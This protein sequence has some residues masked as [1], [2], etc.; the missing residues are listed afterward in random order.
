MSNINNHGVNM[1][2]KLTAIIAGTMLA[3]TGA[4]LPASAFE[5]HTHTLNVA[6][7]GFNSP[8]SQQQNTILLAS[9]RVGT[10]T[11]NNHP[12]T[13]V[14]PVKVKHFTQAAELANHLD[15]IHNRHK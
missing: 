10:R 1:K 7:S 2:G 5:G 4:T 14:R 9:R 3:V 12:K 6:E 8:I 11:T 15:Q 13:G